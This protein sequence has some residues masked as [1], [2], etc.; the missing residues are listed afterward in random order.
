MK[1][2]LCAIACCVMSLE[3]YGQLVVPTATTVLIAGSRYQVSFVS[4]LIGPVRVADGIEML[5]VAS[6]VV[7]SSDGQDGWI[8]VSA[9]LTQLQQAKALIHEVVHIAQNC[10]K[11]D[12][13]VDERFAQD[14]SD[15]INSPEGKFILKELGQ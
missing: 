12:L 8:N 7:C 10:D 15:L 6:E 9:D 2:V 11:R 3:A 5:P 14:I 1:K 13:P 4:G